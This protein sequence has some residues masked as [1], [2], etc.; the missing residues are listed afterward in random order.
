MELIQLKQLVAIAEEKTISRAAERLN[1]SQPALSRSVQKLEDEFGIRLFDRTKN[2][3]KI[4]AAGEAVLEKARILLE[5][6]KNLLLK[7]AAL[8]NKTQHLHIIT[9][10]PAPLWRLS[11]EMG[12][13]F[14]DISLTNALCDEDEIIALLL[15]EKADLAIVRREIEAEAILTLPLT[16]E[17]LFMQIPLTDPLSKKSSIR[18][19]DLAG[20]E[21]R[22]YTGTGFWHNLHRECIS[23]ARYIEYS[24]IM[25]YLN[26]IKDGKSLTFVTALANTSEPTR[27]FCTTVPI[28][29]SEATAHYRLAFLKKNGEKLRTV[30]QWATKAAK[31][32]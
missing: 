31:D 6:E 8:K 13:A 24:D 12:V 21:I 25:V 29:D 1:I 22:E 10:A 16:D 5:D 18:F 20:K 23:G 19:A 3:M 11:A 15:S 9:C 2:S 30:T 17:Q 7:V 14:P 28:T 32:W 4:N 26:A 27:D